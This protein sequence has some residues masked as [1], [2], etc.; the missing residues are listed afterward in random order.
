MPATAMNFDLAMPLPAMIV[1]PA[2]STAMLDF[3]SVM[4]PVMIP[5][6]ILD[7]DFAVPPT[8]AMTVIARKDVQP[9][10]AAMMPGAVAGMSTTTAFFCQHSGS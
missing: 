10:T 4:M 7:L 8:V 6:V 5:A 2:M 9:M 3:K 1:E